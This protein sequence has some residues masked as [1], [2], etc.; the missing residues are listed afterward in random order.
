LNANENVPISTSIGNTGKSGWRLKLLKRMKSNRIHSTRGRD[1]LWL[2]QDFFIHCSEGKG[3][4][5]RYW[6]IN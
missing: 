2:E 6:P 5:S 3:L 1:D 4:Q